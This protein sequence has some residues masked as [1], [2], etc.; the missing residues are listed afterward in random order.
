M[1]RTRREFLSQAALASAAVGLGPAVVHALQ[2][3]ARPY[4][5]IAVRCAEWIDRSAQVKSTGLAWPADPLRA[6]SVGLDY[7]NGMPGVV[8]FFANLY[9]ATGDARWRER[10]QRGGDRKSVV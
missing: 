10:A 5:E 6:A 2:R 8:C 7:Y 9:G 3:T 1:S 4:R